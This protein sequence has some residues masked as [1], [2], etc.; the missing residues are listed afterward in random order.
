ME[1]VQILL[2]PWD[3]QELEKLAEDAQTS[4][5]GVIRDLIRKHVRE[6]RKSKLRK[7]AEL[8]ENEYRTNSEL[9]AFTSLDGEDFLDE[10]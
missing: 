10:S 7:A 4:M 3:K 8:M 1:R 6:Q 5:S 9:T 2:E